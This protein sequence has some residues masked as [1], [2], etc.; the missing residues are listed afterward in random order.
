M[1]KDDIPVVFQEFQDDILKPDEASLEYQ[2]CHPWLRA[3]RPQL[4]IQ[5]STMTSKIVAPNPQKSLA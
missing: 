1:I 3:V 5:P 2:G 4:A